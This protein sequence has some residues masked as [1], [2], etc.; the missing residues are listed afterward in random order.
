[1]SPYVVEDRVAQDVEVGAYEAGELAL[2]VGRGFEK[3]EQQVDVGDR[4][5]ALGPRRSVDPAGCL[6][7]RSTRTVRLGRGRWSLGSA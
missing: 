2:G 5:R 7:A 3:A 4:R 1:M 6:G